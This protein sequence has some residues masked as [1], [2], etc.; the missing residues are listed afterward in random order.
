MSTTDIA[1]MS[2]TDLVA[3]YRARRLSPVE[4]TQ[5]VLGRLERLNP[6]L[7]AFCLSDPAA[8]LES[9]RASEARWSKGQPLGLVDGVPV[10]MKDI[11]V[12]KG[13]PTLRGSRT[14]DPNQ[15]WEEDGP[16]V[17]RLREQGAVLFGT[18]HKVAVRPRVRLS[19]LRK[20]RS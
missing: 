3:A 9:A 6:V 20:S 4:V 1:W 2:A 12:T 5:A 10:S 18:D 16:A 8:A 14:V 19:A 11:I 7:N 17:A 15:P 13:W